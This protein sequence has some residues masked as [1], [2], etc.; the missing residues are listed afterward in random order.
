MILTPEMK[1]WY[2]MIATVGTLGR[3]SKMPGT[4]GSIA[5]TVAIIPYHVFISGVSII[6]LLLSCR[7]ASPLQRAGL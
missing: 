5:G 6:F 3:Y 1:T 7:A 4:L 2:G